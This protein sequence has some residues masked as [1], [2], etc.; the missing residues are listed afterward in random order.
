[1]KSALACALALIAC[2]CTAAQKPYGP[3]EQPAQ[4]RTCSSE[5]SDWR[6]L[7]ASKVERSF[8]VVIAGSATRARGVVELSELRLLFSPYGEYCDPLKARPLVEVRVVARDGS[9]F[10][11]PAPAG[12]SE[13]DE[14]L[15]FDVLDL[16]PDEVAAPEPGPRP[17][18]YVLPMRPDVARVEL[19]AG[20]RTLL[21]LRRTSTMPRVLVAPLA[22]SIAVAYEHEDADYALAQMHIEDGRGTCEPT[23]VAERSGAGILGL[24]AQ[25]WSAWNGHFE[26]DREI[27]PGLD[28]R[29]YYFAPRPEPGLSRGGAPAVVVLS[30]LFHRWTFP[31]PFHASCGGPAV[32][33]GL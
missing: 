9:V 31:L 30:D 6:E 8:R 21:T 17:F 13:M 3:G 7:T 32:A 11:P 28:H 22:P 25:C 27:D 1:M 15:K 23:R 33:S 18:C 10:R 24:G 4:P 26:H 2:A 16:E 5:P 29:D 20:T 19:L 12:P 14:L